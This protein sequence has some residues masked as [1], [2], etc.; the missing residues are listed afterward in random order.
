[1]VRAEASRTPTYTRIHARTNSAP[2]LVDGLCLVGDGRAPPPPKSCGI[3]KGSHHHRTPLRPSRD[4][5]TAHVPTRG[6]TIAGTSVPG[7]TILVALLPAPHRPH[8]A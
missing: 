4:E 5:A 1:M 6:L 7:W 8:A 2:P 3:K